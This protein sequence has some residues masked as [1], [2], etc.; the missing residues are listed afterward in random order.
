[1]ALL[2]KILGVDGLDMAKIG[3]DMTAF[4]GD[5]MALLRNIDERLTRI[6]NLLLQQVKEEDPKDG[7]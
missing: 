2:D 3:Q 1:M 5:G 4:L 7:N 6:E